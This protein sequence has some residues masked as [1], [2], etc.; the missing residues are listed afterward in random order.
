MS[1][2][3]LEPTAP[4]QRGA[5]APVRGVRRRPPT[6]WVHV[7]FALVVL[8]ATVPRIVAVA[9]YRPFL[10]FYGDSFTYLIA[11]QDPS[12]AGSRPF[13]YSALLRLVSWTDQLWLVAVAQHVAI[14]VLGVLLY[15]WL[16]RR[17]SPVW[18]AAIVPTPML[19]DGYQ[20]LTEH[21]AL[22]ETLFVCLLMGC[23][24]LVMRTSVSVN[25][26]LVAGVLLA[27]TALT[28][29]VAVPLILLFVGYLVL[30]RVGW[31]PVVAFMVAFS[32]P[33]I[34]GAAW[35]QQTSGSFALQQ[36][37]RFLYAR[38]APFA[39][40]S[41]LTL[42]PEASQL[43]EATIPATRPSPNFYAW[44]ERSPF[45]RAALPR[46]TDRQETAREFAQAAIIGQPWDYARTV[47][48]DTVQYFGAGR[49]YTQQDTPPSW[50]NF[51]ERPAGPGIQLSLSGS[52]FNNDT[53]TVVR[54]SA[55]G[56]FLRGWQRTLGTQ[57]PLLLFGVL[58]GVAG[59][60]WGRSRRGGVH[61]LDPLLLTG[62]GTGLLFLASATSVF[63]YRYG[64]PAAP[65][66]YLAGGTG[67]LALLQRRSVGR[68]LPTSQRRR[69]AGTPALRRG[70]AAALVVGVVAAV[71]FSPIDPHP[72]YNRY[73]A[74]GAERG[75]LGY[76]VSNEESVSGLDGWLQRR[77]EGG[78]IYLSP[79]PRAYVLSLAADRAYDELGGPGRWGP[80]ISS[81]Q[82]FTKSP[83]DS[84]TWFANGAISVS[85]VRG[86][87]V[88]EPPLLA[89]WCAPD[90]KCPL[91][92]PTDDAQLSDDGT[93]L[94]AFQRGVLVKRP[95][96][97]TERLLRSEDGDKVTRDFIT[98]DTERDAVG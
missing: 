69:G 60:L 56:D 2:T 42:S 54:N 40:C 74:T 57:G 43:C 67:T 70:I 72:I 34:A 5:S 95:G 18:L 14:L 9:G 90:E 11:A 32:I 30:R 7:P 44:D 58:L 31:R 86:T 8:V 12:R 37:G 16:L 45:A 23:A 81:T 47:V 13:G 10:F 64:I 29:S 68:A 71:A 21:A 52:G 96:E 61:R 36:D 1:V 6:W 62:V 63:D 73:A 89:A 98:D 28:R 22:T 24:L 76:P 85:P 84:V 41:R 82:E 26:A 35:Y 39:D 93:V 46:G 88:V 91:G 66:L 87:H 49:S 48:G 83:G 53:V 97:A 25:D 38:V 27:G 55:S 20:V 75:P 51:P 50:W 19:L 79:A 77:F 4:A 33:L 17:G 15:L 59:S 94:Q 80:P 92:T 65:F 78:V 3:D